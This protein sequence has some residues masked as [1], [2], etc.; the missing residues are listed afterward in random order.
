MRKDKTEMPKMPPSAAGA[1][2]EKLVEEVF[3]PRLGDPSSPPE[4]VISEKE[5]TRR[6]LKALGVK[7]PKRPS[8]DIPE[9]GEGDRG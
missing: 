4:S 1:D 9:A 7:V 8:K 5:A 3:N 6:L 2:P